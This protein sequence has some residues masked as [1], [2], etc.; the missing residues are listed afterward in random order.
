MFILDTNIFSELIK[1]K[2]DG[3]VFS[4]YQNLLDQIY[5]ATPVWQELYY[6]WQI[7]P[8]GKKK[9][10]IYHFMT[11][12]VATL[13]HL[14]YTKACADIHATI[15]AKAKQSGKML[16]YVDSEIASIAIS[17]NMILVT[18]NTKDFKNI[19]TLKIENWFE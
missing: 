15:R 9:Q 7:M 18:R 5:L 10:D 3:N 6:G 8:D 19:D 13:P 11:S 4:R 2:M 1:P 12:Q 14:H 16:S 17:N